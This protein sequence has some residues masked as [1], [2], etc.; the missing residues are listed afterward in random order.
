MNKDNKIIRELKYG[1]IINDRNSKKMLRNRI[2][3]TPSDNLLTGKLSNGLVN[4]HIILDSSTAGFNVELPPLGFNEETS[5]WFMNLNSLGSGNNV[6]LTGRSINFIL[7]SFTVHYGEI[8]IVTDSLDGTY[9][10]TRIWSE[11]SVV[12]YI[13]FNIDPDTIS[14]NQG[15]LYY[16][17]QDDVLSVILE[18]S[19]EQIG[20]EIYAACYNNTGSDIPDGSVVSLSGAQGQR[21]TI[22][23][24][25]IDD[26]D[27]ALRCLGITTHDIPKNT[28]GKVTT[29]GKVR[30]QDTSSFTAGDVLYASSTPGEPTNVI[31]TNG[32]PRVVVGVVLNSHPNQGEIGVR[33]KEVRYMFGDVTGGD[34]AIFRDTGKLDFY[35]AGRPYEDLQVSISNIK[36][37]ASQAPTEQLYNG[38][39]AGGV[40]FPFLGFDVNDYIYF[41][42]QTSHAMPLNTVLDHHIHY[43]LPN[44][45]DIGDNFK[46]QLDVISAG[47][48]EAWQVPTGSPYTA[49]FQVAANDDSYHR[50]LDIA[51]I[52]AINTTVSTI[53]KCRLKRIAASS[54]EYGS[55]IYI[56]FT[57]SHYRK[58]GLGST[59]ESTK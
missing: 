53:Y 55:E 22:E 31:P 24:T 30:N 14:S 48:N 45:T 49:E 15:T 10:I 16:D 11:N 50:Y 57:D 44:T 40:E 52:A 23:L 2:K 36:V 51:E 43:S 6:T 12:D 59:T 29:F 3:L 17:A 46:F 35:G 34:Y 28:T 13:S 54:N 56:T 39:I 5:L 20:E 27:N 41:D 38:G 19:T 58:D 7:T 47:M 32:M 37:P 42:L 9:L 26:Y 18:N 1:N 25:D 33:L 8:V 21:P 4:S